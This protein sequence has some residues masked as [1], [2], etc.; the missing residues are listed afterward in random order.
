MA[1]TVADVRAQ[2][3]QN[4][5][6]SL[7]MHYSWL[8]ESSGVGADRPDNDPQSGLT[9]SLTTIPDRVARVH[10]TIESILRQS[11]RPERVVLWLDRE[12][13]AGARLPA[14][15]RS[16][17]TRG[18]E[19]RYCDDLRSYK[20]LIPA[21]EQF[22][23]DIIVTCDDDVMYP[24]EWLE[25]LYKGHVDAPRTVLCHRAHEI[26]IKENA[27]APYAEWHA[28][29][30]DHRPS[31]RI[32]PTGVGGVLYPPGA[33]HPEVLNREQFLELAPT[34]DDIW[35]KTM[36]LY[37]EVRCQLVAGNMQLDKG[38]PLDGIYSILGTQDSGLWRRNVLLAEN[39]KQLQSA[40][41]AYSVMPLLLKEP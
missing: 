13:F 28:A 16:Q 17:Q 40:F 5:A 1:A 6:N 14:Q 23:T 15:L 7:V 25:R 24:M 36:S 11:L 3:E 26:V 19:I 9:V 33:L 27:V 2:G 34:G 35:F 8:I 22:P 41:G 38:G 32:F 31:F 18:L 30:S 4:L 29:V 20:K 37:N 12:N 10:L 21:L 39:D